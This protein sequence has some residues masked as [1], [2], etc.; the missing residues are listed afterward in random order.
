MKSQKPYP[1]KLALAN[2]KEAL[3]AVRKYYGWSPLNRVYMYCYHILKSKM[4]S[5]LLTFNLP[6]VFLSVPYALVR[7]VGM[8]RGIRLEDLQ[9]DKTF[10]HPQAFYGLDGHLQEILIID[11]FPLHSYY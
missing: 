10:Q 5:A 2:H 9:D 6:L 8:N 7:Y 1:Q 4:P 3:E 11:G